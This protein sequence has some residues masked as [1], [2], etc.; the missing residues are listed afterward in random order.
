MDA[1]DDSFQPR[2]DASRDAL[3]DA[4]GA[5]AAGDSEGFRA[6]WAQFAQAASGLDVQEL[7]D[8]PQLPADAGENATALS[9]MLERIPRGHGRWIDCER[10]WHPIV[11]ALDAG[12]AEIFPGYELHECKQKYGSLRFSFG[13]GEELC[14]PADPEPE[15]PGRDAPEQDREAWLAAM[16]AWR[17]SR[18]DWLETPAGQASAASLNA[19][20][21]RAKALS[22]AAEQAAAATCELCG[23]A[24]RMTLTRAASPWHQVLCAGCAQEHG[25]I[26]AEDW[27]A[28]WE[29]EEPRHEARM[30]AWFAGRHAGKAVLVIAADPDLRISIDGACYVND[31][32]EAAGQAAGDWEMVFLDGSEPARAYM[33]ALRERHAGHVAGQAARAQARRDAGELSPHIKPPDGAPWLLS[34]DPGWGELSWTQDSRALGLSCWTHQPE[35]L[36]GPMLPDED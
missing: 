4:V 22:K 9:A 34:L 18:D 13:L 29:Q 26:P 31:P 36:A 17:G 10:G 1:S 2:V 24:G 25:A 19:R 35:H 6:A 33:A 27:D 16:K 15:H 20:A 14:D 11:I 30:R 3:Q 32:D 12:L 21:Q 5:A 7:I 28:W 23:A 8:T